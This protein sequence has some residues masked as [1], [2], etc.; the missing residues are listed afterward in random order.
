MRPG[1]LATGMAGGL[2]GMGGIQKEETMQSLNDPLAIYLDRV[3]SL[4]TDNHKLKSKIWEHLEKKGPQ[5][6][7]WTHYF[8]TI[9][10]LRAQIFTNT[11]DNACTIL[12]IDNVSLAADDFAVKYE[13]ELA[14]CQSMENNIHGLCKAIDD[15]NV[16]WLQLETEIEAL[17]EELLFMNKNHKEEVKGL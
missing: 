4:K 9:E 14:V 13:R 17:K 6:K 1:G 7:D 8:K 10:D 12:Q 11:V 15:T 5:V 3:R 2:A 16:T